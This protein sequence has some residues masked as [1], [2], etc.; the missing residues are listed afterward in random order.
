MGPKLAFLRHDPGTVLAPGLFRSLAPGERK[1]GNLDVKY[2]FGDEQLHFVGRWPLGADDLRVLQGIVAHFGQAGDM[3]DDPAMRAEIFADTKKDNGEDILI[4]DLSYR[5]IAQEV[6]YANIDDSK[7]IKESIK[8]LFSTTVF[9]SR[10]G[11]EVGYHLIETYKSCAAA[12]RVTIALNPRITVAVLGEGTRYARIDMIEV[13]EIKLDVT[14]LVHQRLSGWLNQGGEAKLDLETLKK[15][16]WSNPPPDP[17]KA[18]NAE[19]KRNSQVRRALAELQN[20]GWGVDE[21]QPRK[22]TIKRP[23]GHKLIAA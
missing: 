16:I 15:Y 4:A 11:E 18:Q 10:G 8:R 23:G 19:K 17:K 9:V 7:S 14:R 13:R 21:Y 20:L 6:G 1:S 2:K 22:F 5:Q 3:L 12:G